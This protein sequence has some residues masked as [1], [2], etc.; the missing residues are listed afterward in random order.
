MPD[1]LDS[2]DTST[3]RRLLRT[4]PRDPSIGWSP[5]CLGWSKAKF[6]S[7]LTSSR[8]RSPRRSWRQRGTNA[9]ARTS[10]RA[11]DGIFMLQVARV[12]AHAAPTSLEGD[13]PTNHADAP[14]PRARRRRLPQRARA[15]GDQLLGLVPHP[16][17]RRRG[18]ML[19]HGRRSTRA[20]VEGTRSEGTQERLKDE[21]SVRRVSRRG[22]PV[23]LVGM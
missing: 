19:V 11:N 3:P 20:R 4:T 8:H 7:S 23:Q 18:R 2:A 6:K 12:L 13:Q 1:Q 17:Y 16:L 21:R 14:P 22:S 5:L 9:R 15:R 10:G